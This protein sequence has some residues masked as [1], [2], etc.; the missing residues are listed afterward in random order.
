VPDRTPPRSLVRA[1]LGLRQLL[2]RAADRLV[3]PEVALFNH[4]IGFGLTRTLGAIAEHRV[5]D[6][7]GDGKAT[8][9]ALAERLGLDA[10]SLH[11][12]LRAG[13]V[14]GLVR[15][16]R[17][18]R[19]RLTSIGQALREDHP[20]SMR[21]WIRYLNLPSTQ[22]AWAGVGDTLRTGEPSFPAVH[23]RSVW[24]H[25]ADTPEEER[26]F[27]TAM[28]KFTELDVP[29]VVEGYPWPDNGT[30]CDVA[31][32]V[33]T[34]LAGVLQARPELEGVLVDAPGVLSEAEAHLRSAGVRDRVTLSEGDMFE[35]VDA[36]ADIYLLKD[37]LHDWDDERCLDILRTVRR[38]MPA[39]ARVV[40]VETL[41]EPGSPDSIAS[42]VDVHMMT[43]C[44]G[45]RQRSAPEFHALM[46]EVGLQPG[47]VR[48]TGGPALV[49]GVAA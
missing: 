19:F 20:H 33:G 8:A 45:G 42:L 38:A 9:G 12:L 24:Q 16:D 4:S 17:R 28:Q 49:E 5:A 7:L 13:A 36:R 32:G 14:Y 22:A 43:Q 31:G 3:P 40:L 48:L 41:Q 11:R 18:G 23:G 37:V 35:R 2:L 27:A 25:F 44:D 10:D 1:V 39:G 46:R 29:A 30:V 15:L 34:L 26:I 47:E 21:A 6:E